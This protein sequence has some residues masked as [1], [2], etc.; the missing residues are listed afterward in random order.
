MR[1]K[2]DQNLKIR[3]AFKL[4]VSFFHKCG[5]RNTYL[6]LGCSVPNTGELPM[7][8]AATGR[9]RVKTFITIALAEEGAFTP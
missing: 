5:W 7:P 1:S 8:L 3:I 9:Q 2:W 4:T 6:Y